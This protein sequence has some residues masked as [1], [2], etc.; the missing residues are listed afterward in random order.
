MASRGCLVAR[1][2]SMTIL[3]THVA[4][5][6][7]TRDARENVALAADHRY[8]WFFR[9][10]QATLR[11]IEFSLLVDTGMC[12]KTRYLGFWQD[13]DCED[14]LLYRFTLEELAS[15]AHETAR[16]TTTTAHLAL[17]EH[18]HGHLYV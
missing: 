11:S 2:F 16:A 18:L 12:T 3:D 9:P 15:N 14:L 10:N 5:L 1:S 13:L 7:A 8:T 4:F 6:I 17:H